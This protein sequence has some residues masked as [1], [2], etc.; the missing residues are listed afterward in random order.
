MPISLSQYEE[1]LLSYNM[2]VIY[3]ADS[4]STDCSVNEHKD[5]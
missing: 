4:D 1:P 3:V 5:S 2:D